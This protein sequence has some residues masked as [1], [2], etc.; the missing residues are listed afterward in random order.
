MADMTS[1][2]DCL[3]GVEFDLKH[4]RPHA[5]RERLVRL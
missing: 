2:L 1:S 4:D 5:N 3:E